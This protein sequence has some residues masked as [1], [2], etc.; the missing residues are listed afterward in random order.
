MDQHD[1]YLIYINAQNSRIDYVEFTMRDLMKSYKGVVH[2]K[3]HKTVQGILMPF[4]IGI[5]DG[6]EVIFW[7]RSFQFHSGIH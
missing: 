7:M 4:W 6:C 2:Y 3:N 1:Q 5:A